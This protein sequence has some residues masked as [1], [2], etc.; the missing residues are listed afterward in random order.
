[1]HELLTGGFRPERVSILVASGTHRRLADAEIRTMLDERVEQAGIAVRCHDAFDQAGLVPLG[2][3]G[4]GTR[5]TIDRGYLE[6]DF[7]IL[8]GLVETHFMAGA[9]GGR[10][11]ICPG[12]LGIDSI[13]EFHG[14]TILAD[15]RSTDLA[16]TGNPC[17]ELSLEIARMAPADFI[18]NVTTRGDGAVV[19][20]FAGDMERA[21][22]AAVQN[23]RG[24]A[25]IPIHEHY[26]VV[27]A[28]AGKVGVNHY[29]AAK[30]ASAAAKPVRHGGYVILLADTVDP[31]PVGSEHYRGMMTLLRDIGPVAFDRLIRSSEWTFVPDQ[32]E[33]QMWAR[34]FDRVPPCNFF[35]FSPQTPLFEYRRLPCREPEPWVAA[36]EG[37][38][39]DKQMAMFV[40]R[41]TETALAELVAAGTAAPKIA[42]LPAGPYGIPV[43]E[44][45][46][47]PA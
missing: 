1:V 44:S 9:S 16:T 38:A 14:P 10:K 24:F 27:V 32:W 8:T 5:V 46:A 28:H 35:Y 21:H 43:Q 18:L 17:H 7:R 33:V 36:L 41:A 45:R 2:V 37:L 47:Y 19:G 12:L 20:A 42:F 23:L 6:A 31:D 39:P 22:E 15:P 25:E 30:A 29:Q 40:S 11:S 26:D 4:A 13:R 3:T 34:F